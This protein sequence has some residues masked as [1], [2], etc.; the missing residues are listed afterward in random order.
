MA[1]LITVEQLEAR[2][3]TDFSGTGLTQAEALIADASGLVRQ[4]ARWTDA[5]PASVPASIVAVVAQMIRR[6]LDNPSE[7]TAEQ[8]GA[9]GWQAQHSSAV[10]GASLYITRAERRIIR[11][12]AARPAVIGISGDTGLTDSRAWDDEVPQ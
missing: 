1:D 6:A 12:A 9:Y 3:A 4:V 5:E 8:I 11:D 7:R 2:L 10:T